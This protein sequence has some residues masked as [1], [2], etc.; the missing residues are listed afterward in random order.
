MNW[1]ELR[2][3]G[4]IF[5]HVSEI[6]RAEE[7]YPRWFRETIW[8]G[9][10]DALRK[11][12]EE[13]HEIYGLFDADGLVA[14]VY[15]EKPQEPDAI[16]IHLSIVRRVDPQ[17]FIEQASQLRNYLFRRGIFRIRGWVLRQN[18]GLCEIL[19]GIGFL[20]TGISMR[21]GEIRGRILTW[22]LFEV[23]QW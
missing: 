15:V 21:F 7:R 1:R 14:C 3:N 20:E 18:R 5:D 17:W 9:S 10:E 13:S 12:L 23:R 8:S 22:R 16:W 4:E 19:R 2:K 11:F 6:W